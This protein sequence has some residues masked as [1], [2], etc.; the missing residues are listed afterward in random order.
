MIGSNLRVSDSDYPAKSEMLDSNF[1]TPGT[2]RTNNVQNS[3]CHACAAS[4]ERNAC[5]RDDADSA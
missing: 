5:P 2:L 4:C 3:W 1:S